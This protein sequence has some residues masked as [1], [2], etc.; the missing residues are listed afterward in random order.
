MTE[1]PPVLIRRGVAADAAS[2]ADFGRRQ[3]A[4]TFAAGNDPADLAA[5]LDA[6][7]SEGAQGAELA[8]PRVRVLVAEVAGAWAG[9]A[10]V[11]ARNAVPAS[12]PGEV[13]WQ[14]ERFYVDRA[15]HGQGLAD[16]LMDAALDLVA[17]EGAQVAWLTVWDRNARAIAFYRRRGFI[18][19]GSTVFMVGTDAQVDRVLARPVRDRR[20]S[21]LPRST[22]RRPALVIRLQRGAAGRDFVAGVRADGSSSWLRRPGGVPRRDRALVA[23]EAT[24]ALPHGVFAQVAAGAEVAE[25]FEPGGPARGDAAGWSM[26]LAALLDAEGAQ[27]RLGGASGIAAALGRPPAGVPD[28]DDTVLI[29][30][31]GAFARLELAWR[32]LAAGDALEF[33]V[34]VER[35]AG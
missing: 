20:T 1:S 16:A 25:F 14:L 6:T 27:P 3:Y 28:L 35:S 8:H 34:G 21:P 17:H 5:H 24:L 26:R 7:Y 13:P 4:A 32:G 2:L 15:F 33:A 22:V 18:D 30:L 10:L 11:S 9:Y 29:A 31:R 12:V 23:I 19:V